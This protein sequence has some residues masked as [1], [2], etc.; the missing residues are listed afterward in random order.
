MIPHDPSSIREILAANISR[1]REC[2]AQAA[3]KVGRNPEEITLVAVTKTV[4]VD[5]IAELAALGISDIGENRVHHGAAKRQALATLPIKWHF[6]GHL[7]RNKVKQAL[8]S[9]DFYHSLDSTRLAQEM[10]NRVDAG[11]ISVL[12]EVNISSE[13][14]KHG[15]SRLEVQSEIE[16]LLEL[17]QLEIQG[18]MTMAPFTSDMAVC[19]HCF[20]ELKNLAGEL[21]RRYP[22]ELKLRHL[23]MGMSQDYPIAVEEGA[24]MVRVGSALFAGIH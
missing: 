20:R 14:S 18:L 8:A 16:K 2:I 11:K 5:I 6:I 13:D 17:P 23:S 1:V 24:T 3:S 9:F 7:Q 19:R 15:F 10:A 12:L 21:Q 22:K 4:S